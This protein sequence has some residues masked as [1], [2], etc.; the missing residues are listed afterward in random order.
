MPTRTEF[1]VL[2]KKVTQESR[3][4]PKEAFLPTI[5]PNDEELSM[6]HECPMAH[7]K[8]R[9]DPLRP[10]VILSLAILESLPGARLTVF[11]ALSHARVAREQAVRFERG[12]EIKIHLEQRAGNAVPDSASLAK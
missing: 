2:K 12:P 5:K 3:L 6:T 7:D 11:L 10:L 1:L 9:H 4:N 8:F